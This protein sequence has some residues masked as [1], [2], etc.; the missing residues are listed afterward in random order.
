MFQAGCFVQAASS[1]VS[2]IA[3]AIAIIVGIWLLLKPVHAKKSARIISADDTFEPQLGTYRYGIETYHSS[4]SASQRRYTCKDMKIETSD[5]VIHDVPGPCDIRCPGEGNRLPIAVG[6]DG[7]IKCRSS[8]EKWNT[9]RCVVRVTGE[10]KNR[11][12]DVPHDGTCGTLGASIDVRLSKKGDMTLDSEYQNPEKYGY[13]VLGIG[14][15][16]GLISFAGFAKANSREGCESIM[17]EEQARLQ[18]GGGM[19]NFASGMLLG[20]MINSNSQPFVPMGSDS[21]STV[22]E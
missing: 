4:Q 9:C 21:F 13:I 17:L 6:K 7:D 22:V 3:S 16:V 20:S 15:I 5:G 11:E 12:L 2:L 19:G 14:V 18:G 8:G 1:F 10:K